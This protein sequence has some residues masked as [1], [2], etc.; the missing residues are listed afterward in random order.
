MAVR[1]KKFGFISLI[2]PGKGYEKITD[3]DFHRAFAEATA[4]MD[5]AFSDELYRFVK[6]PE[7]WIKEHGKQGKEQQG[8]LT[9]DK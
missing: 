2:M 7:K 3:A 9:P 1:F 5:R 4:E 8:N 6:D